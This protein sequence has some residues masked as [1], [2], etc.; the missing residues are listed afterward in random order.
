[1]KLPALRLIRNGTLAALAGA[2]VYLGI[3]LSALN[4]KVQEHPSIEQLNSIQSHI[5]QVD[6]Q[7][8]WMHLTLARPDLSVQMVHS[9]LL[10][11]GGKP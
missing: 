6:S 2:S 9:S 7:L 5:D 10:V 4:S 8:D 1:M 3:E 11:S